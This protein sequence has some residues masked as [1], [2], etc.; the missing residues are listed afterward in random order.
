LG[1]EVVRSKKGIHLCQRKYALDILEET[2]MLG[3]KPC[4]T[5]LMSNTKFLFET[6]DKIQNPNPY[7]RLISKLLYLTNT[8]LYIT[9]VVQLLSQFVQEPSVRHQ[10][11][12]QHILHYIKA[13]HAHGLFFNNK[14]EVHIKTVSYSDWTFCPNTR[15]S[16][17]D[18]CIFLATLLFPGKQHNN[19]C[20]WTTMNQLYTSWPSCYSL[21][22]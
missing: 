4:F 15:Y 10:P 19:Y 13:N 18:Y 8:R 9:F 2:G 20:L 22:W 5:P 16:T 12:V 11:V 1:L 7:R 14:Y 17:T 6:V 21:F 3:S